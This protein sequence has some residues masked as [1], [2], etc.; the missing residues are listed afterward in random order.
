[1]TSRPYD[2]TLRRR[3]AAATRQRVIEAA[4]ELFSRDGYGAT[5]VARIAEVAGVSTETVRTIG[6]KRLLLEEATVLATFGTTE[7]LDLGDI[8]TSSEAMGVDVHD[9][10]SWLTGMSS[11]IA[12][13]NA[14]AAGIFRAFASAAADDPEIAE[15]WAAQQRTVRSAWVEFIAWLDRQGWIT[16]SADRDDLATTVWLLTLADTYSRIVVTGVDDDRYRRWLE[17]SLRDLLFPS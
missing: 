4:L 9:A 17:A 16:S 1:M 5:S 8:T 12:R 3:Q 13:L 10:E 14:Q 2:S 7:H 15:S 6:P 11:I